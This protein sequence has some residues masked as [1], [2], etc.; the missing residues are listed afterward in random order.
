MSRPD[1]RGPTADVPIPR[2]PRIIKRYPNRKL[3]DV[4]ESCYVT[5]EEIADLV[6]MG[7]EVRVFDNRTHEDLT[8]VTLAQIIFE[9]EKKR[10]Q[11]PLGLLLSMIRNRGVQIGGQIRSGAQ[12]VTSRAGAIR[13]RLMTSKD[14]EKAEQ[15]QAQAAG[16]GGLPSDARDAA[17]VR[18]GEAAQQ[19]A[20]E[21]N[22][23]SETRP[24]MERAEASSG[25][26]PGAAAKG[27][28]APLGQFQKSLDDW[29]KDLDSRVHQ[30]IEQ[31]SSLSNIASEMRA[32][33]Q[34][35]RELEARLEELDNE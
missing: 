33:E 31:L 28:K 10:S 23:P 34:R 3:Y 14:K 9:E 32:M 16:Q 17:G 25:G 22:A 24:P 8:S 12:Q 2:P 4:E 5:L 19:R 15:S 27:K 6:R 35:I 21:G 13:E 18:K 11:M 29:H 1:Q 26:K 7:E 30:T 20:A